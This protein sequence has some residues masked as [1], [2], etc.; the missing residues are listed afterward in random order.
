MFRGRLLVIFGLLVGLTFLPIPLTKIA[1]NIGGTTA[2]AQVIEVKGAHTYKEDNTWGHHLKIFGDMAEKQ[3]NG[4][5]KF[6]YF[7]GGTLYSTYPDMVNGA[8]TGVTPFAHMNITLLTPFDSNWN[9]VFTPGV[10]WGWEHWKRFEKT[11]VYK[12][13][14]KG[15][16]EKAGVKLLYWGCT[17]P[18]GDLVFNKKRPIVTLDDWKGLKIRTSP[19]ESA[20]LLVKAF[21]A[22]PIVLSSPEV[23]T[24]L[25]QGVVD[26][27]IITMSTGVPAWTVQKTAPYV[28]IQ[29]GERSLGSMMVGMIANLKFWNSLPPDLRK[30]IEEGFPEAQATTLKFTQKRAD[31]AFELFKNTPGTKITYLTKDQTQLWTDIVDQ[32]VITAM[33]AKYPKEIF[34]AARATRPK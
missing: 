14:T 32:K 17:I 4:K 34:E 5:I 3:T 16:E 31:E 21:G 18:G 13:L 33:E 9:A 28:T 8:V 22:S 30:A 11:E 1:V 15:L 24:A 12:R 19:A 10:I 25:E 20:I 27:G 26:G 29:H 7:W 2:I 6:K 23:A